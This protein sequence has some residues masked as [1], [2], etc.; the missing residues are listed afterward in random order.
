MCLEHL[1]LSS[2]RLSVKTENLKNL[3][4]QSKLTVIFVKEDLKK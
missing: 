1:F 4:I 2:C 3:R